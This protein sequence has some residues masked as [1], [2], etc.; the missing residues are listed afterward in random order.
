MKMRASSKHFVMLTSKNENGKMK[1]GHHG[2]KW[3]VLGKQEGL[4]FSTDKSVHLKLLSRD[5]S[6]LML[7]KE[8]NDPDFDIRTV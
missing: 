5:G 3:I 2:E 6:K 1:L 8:Q 7:V 4:K